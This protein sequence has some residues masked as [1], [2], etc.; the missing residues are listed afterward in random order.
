MA[1]D[2]TW[3]WPLTEATLRALGCPPPPATGPTLDQLAVLL[4][5]KS[6]RGQM[7]AAQLLRPALVE[8]VARATS[9]VIVPLDGDVEQQQQQQDDDEVYAALTWAETC[10]IAVAH[11]LPLYPQVL[12]YVL[13]RAIHTFTVP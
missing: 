11:L 2:A 13:I 7:D 1:T 3:Q 4:V 5:R 8:L 6:A 10:A 9:M 12:L